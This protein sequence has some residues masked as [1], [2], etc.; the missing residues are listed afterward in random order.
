M[1][2]NELSVHRSYERLEALSFPSST[3][4]ISPPQEGS[5]A[6]LRAVVS[7]DHSRRG[8]VG[9]PSLAWTV[10]R[11]PSHRSFFFAALRSRRTRFHV[12]RFSRRNRRVFVGAV[13]AFCTFE[14]PAA[15]P[16]L[17]WVSMS[18]RTL[19]HTTPTHIHPRVVI[20]DHLSIYRSIMHRQLVG[21]RL[22]IV[23][24]QARLRARLRCRYP[25]T[26]TLRPTAPHTHR[27]AVRV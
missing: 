11:S 24:R 1:R 26:R 13:L 5:L 20:V 16:S 3:R 21:Q 14:E 25:M 27:R 4:E 9:S 12:A 2:L 23:P 6:R 18:L 15:L 10:I 17:V 19:V 22:T 7:R 8:H